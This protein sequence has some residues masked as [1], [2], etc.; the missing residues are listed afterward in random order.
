ML[1]KLKFTNRTAGDDGPAEIVEMQ[2]N[3]EAVSH[4]LVWYGAFYAGDDY[5]VRLNG[6]K[7]RLGINGEL[8]VPTIDAK[9]SRLALPKT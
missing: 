5:D 1:V 6:K 2:I 9:P 3:R 4:V 7:L 8:E